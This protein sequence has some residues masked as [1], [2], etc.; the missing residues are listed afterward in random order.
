LG[1]VVQHLAPKLA[2][3]CSVDGFEIYGDPGPMATEVAG[4]FCAAIFPYW[5]GICR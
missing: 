1:P 5:M 2:A 4:G 3:A